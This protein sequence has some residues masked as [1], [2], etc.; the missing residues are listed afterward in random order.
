M[1]GWQGPPKCAKAG[2][3][4]DGRQQVLKVCAHNL[5]TQQ[6]SN[7]QLLQ[8]MTV[9]QAAA[10]LHGCWCSRC[11]PCFRSGWCSPVAG[12]ISAAALGTRCWCSRCPPCFRSGWCS[13]LAGGISAAA[14]GTRSEAQ[15]VSSSEVLHDEGSLPVLGRADSHEVGDRWDIFWQAHTCMLWPV[16][17]V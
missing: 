9:P 8:N 2:I 16:S 11:P 13:P 7:V 15:L 4:A 14:L 6:L 1:T 5:Q 17:G 3:I 10:A 12:D